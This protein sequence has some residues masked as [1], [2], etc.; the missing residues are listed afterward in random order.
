MSKKVLAAAAAAFL[1]AI[2]SARASTVIDLTSSGASDTQT[3]QIGGS[4]TVTQ[5]AQQPTGTGYI[6]SFLRIDQTG[7]EQGYNTGAAQNAGQ[8]PYDDMF[9]NFTRALQLSEIPVVKINGVDYRQFILDINQTSANP[10]LSL[11]QIQIFQSAADVGTNPAGLTAAGKGS[12]PVV[13]FNNATE[14]FRM[15]NASDSSFYEIQLDYSLNSGSGSGDMYL[16]V[17]DSDFKASNSSYITLYSQFGA[18]PGA[19]SSN[20]GF[21]EWAVLKPTTSVVP[22]PAGAALALSGIVGIGLYSLRYRRRL[23]RAAA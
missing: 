17:R 19:Y 22:V 3:A 13:A 9:G 12:A 2:P 6:D 5:M 11:N 7:S 8:L 4:F 21:E 23:K 1:L 10:K 20:D 16:Y 18:P 14:V 15:N